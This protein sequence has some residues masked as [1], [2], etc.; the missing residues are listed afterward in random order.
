MQLLEFTLRGVVVALI[1]AVLGVVFVG[2][3]EV[4]GAYMDPGRRQAISHR[5]WRENLRHLLQ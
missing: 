5:T 3:V 1:A 2:A 4:I